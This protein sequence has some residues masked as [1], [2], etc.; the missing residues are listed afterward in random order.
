MGM[1]HGYQSPRSD[2]SVGVAFLLTF[3]FGPL[4]VFYVAVLPAVILTVVAIVVGLVTLGLAVPLVWIGSIVWGCVDASRQHSAFQASI[5]LTQAGVYGVAHGPMPPL[6]LPAPGWYADPGG[7]G[8]LRWWDGQAWSNHVQPLSPQQLPTGLLPTS[9]P[10][11]PP[12]HP[13]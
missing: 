3:F 1:Q 6:T 13:T 9:P 10:V 12:P 2:K 4:G 7:A 8:V 5:A 11:P